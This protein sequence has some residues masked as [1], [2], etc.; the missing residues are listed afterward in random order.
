MDQP[1][2][3]DSNPSPAPD[4]T[5]RTALPDRAE[6]VA[7]PPPPERAALKDSF[8]EHLRREREM[9]G[10]TLEEI[11][12]AT[13]IGTRFLEALET[14]R[15]DRLPGGIFNR[16]FVRTT[17]QFLGLDPEAMIAE[18]TLATAGSA[19]ND[20]APVLIHSQSSW[21]ARPSPSTGDRLWLPWVVLV[22]IL[23]IAAGGWFGWRHYRALRRARAA[24]AAL[25]G[26]DSGL[27]APQPMAPVPPTAQDES[28]TASST[29]SDASSASEPASDSTPAPYGATPATPISTTDSANETAPNSD[30]P[31]A[32]TSPAATTGAASSD[33]AASGPTPVSAPLVLK[34]EA[35]RATNIKV[36]VDGHKSF[37]GKIPAGG[38]KTFYANIVFYVIASDPGG[39]L[40]EL[41]GQTL[42]P[43]GPPGHSAGIR[44]SRE[45]LTSQ[46]GTNH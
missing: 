17:A 32:A 24:E 22:V 25:A 27:P 8:G 40:L 16:G 12:A 1:R 28:A 35:G 3:Q 11:S 26:E 38:S 20:A 31:A 29:A 7:S 5:E 23:A 9:R 37:Q 4:R 33:A 14:E 10:V 41:N 2:A 18:Y 21:T 36:S 45:S 39:V 15:W 42:P 34:I 44:L 19:R 43:M 30:M 13:R 6:R 46:D